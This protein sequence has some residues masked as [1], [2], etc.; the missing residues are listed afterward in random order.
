MGKSSVIKKIFF[1]SLIL[2]SV[3]LTSCVDYVQSVSL[4]NGKYELYYKLTLS[5]ILLALA[6][7]DPNL[8]LDEITKDFSSIEKG[9]KTVN[10]D[11]EIGFELAVSVDK[12]TKDKEEKELI[13]TVQKNKIL[14]PFLP[15]Q[16]F[17]SA[18]LSPFSD[19]FDDS[20]EITQ[21]ILSSAKAR[22]LIGKEIAPEIET[23]Y[24][25]GKGGKSY[26]I[27]VYNYGNSFC[28]EIPFGV[29]LEERMYDFSNI[30][31]IC[32]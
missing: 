21:A 25:E 23:A 31:I 18:G 10:T 29:L 27:P 16:A 3:L 6:E 17:E 2:T 4:K 14:I 24:F 1:F 28:L 22:V 19:D 30:V 12:N 8:Y 11:T 5:K 7:T 26:S 20:L 9:F 32:L 15:S 13:P